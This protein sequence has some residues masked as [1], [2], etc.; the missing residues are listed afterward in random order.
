MGTAT[1]GSL[2]GLEP[3]G[4]FPL[5]GAQHPGRFPQEGVGGQH[6]IPV[7]RGFGGEEGL[8]VRGRAGGIA[9]GLAQ[10]LPAGLE[11]VALGLERVPVA[12]QEG[13]DLGA[14]GGIQSEAGVEQ[15][16]GRRGWRRLEAGGLE[17]GEEEGH[18]GSWGV[19]S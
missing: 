11:G 17:E 7:G 10:G 6:L 4:G 14:L 18:G 15:G 8:Q 9:Q 19:T 2:L 3:G 12:G 16:E 1:V 13:L 5:L